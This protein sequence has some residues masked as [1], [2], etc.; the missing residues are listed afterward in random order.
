MNTRSLLIASLLGG[1]ISTALVNTPF[2]NLVNLLVCA[3][4][5]LGP[6]AAV[7]L[8]RRLGAPLALGQA[9]IVGLLAGAWHALFGLLLSPFGL[10]GAGGLLNDVR[11]FFPADD[12]AG[13]ERALSGSG[14]FLFNLIGV[15]VDLAFGLFG[16]LL[17]GVLFGLRPA[18]R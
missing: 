2:V 16:G 13:L 17:G 3:G 11:A 9:V 6:I 5:W 8:Y 15:A 7:W 12:L 14:A 1:L 10:A 4:F 18:H